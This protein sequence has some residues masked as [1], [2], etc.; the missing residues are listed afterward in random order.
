MVVDIGYILYDI[1]YCRAVK[2]LSG[3]EHTHLERE[4]NKIYRL[5]LESQ[6]RLLA[7]KGIFL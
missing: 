1:S 4:L 5:L 7:L 6:D 2:L 3:K